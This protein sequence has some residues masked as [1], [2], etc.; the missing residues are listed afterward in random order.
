MNSRQIYK[1][2]MII[3]V[4]I[5]ILF[6]SFNTIQASENHA[7]YK[8]IK[9]AYK[10]SELKYDS[11]VERVLFRKLPEPQ[12]IF[13]RSG[14]GSELPK[15]KNAEEE[16]IMIQTIEALYRRFFKEVKTGGQYCPV[17][18]IKEHFGQT[19]R[20]RIGVSSGGYYRLFVA[21]WPWLELFSQ[22]QAQT[23]FPKFNAVRVSKVYYKSLHQ[24]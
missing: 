7:F 22:P 11:N 1:S 19:P 3:F 13:E 10:D 2:L 16:K 9:E 24:Q 5:H 17:E 14:L 6:C 4:I 23:R 12:E 21:Y 18:K 8:Y 20:E 15:P